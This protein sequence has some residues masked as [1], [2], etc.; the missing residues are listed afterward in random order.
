MTEV[1]RFF[2]V[3]DSSCDLPKEL[4]DTY[5]DFALC[6][7]TFTIDGEVNPV[8]GNKEFYDRLRNGSRSQTSQV[9]PDAFLETFRSAADRGM[10]VLYVGFSS[11]LSGTVESG[12]KAAAV[13]EKEYPER[14]FIVIDTLSASCGEGCLVDKAVELRRSGKTIDETAQ[15][16]EDNKLR[17]HHWYTVDD[18]HFLQRGG[19]V[20]AS[21]AW[22]GSAL[23]IKPVMNMDNA[24]HLIPRE[25][26]IGRKRSISGLFHKLKVHGIK[27][28][29]KKIFISHGDC[30]NEV[31]MLVD[32]IK[33]EWGT[34]EFVISYVGNVIGSHTGPG[35]IALYF[36]GDP[37]ENWQG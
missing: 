18:L 24:G 19:R 11:G 26:V 13:A 16:L 27:E 12:A 17:L 23:S 28:E 14:K 20:S 25:K 10:D 29:N 9:N 30:L 35:V 22:F 37:R 6:P 32:M 31:M 5:E 1:N 34:E 36:F 3:T 21:A 2:I 15:W 4:L 7:L 8:L 33:K